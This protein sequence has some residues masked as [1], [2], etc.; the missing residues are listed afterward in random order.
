MLISQNVCT[1]KPDNNSVKMTTVD[2]NNFEDFKEKTNSLNV[3]KIKNINNL[4]EQ[5]MAKEKEK[6][7]SNEMKK[8]FSVLCK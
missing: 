3:N 5:Q 6:C 7:C 4:V 2:L 8:H 1:E